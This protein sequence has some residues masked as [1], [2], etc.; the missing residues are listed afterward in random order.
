M[1]GV[2][3]GTGW[4]VGGLVGHN[5][6]EITASHATVVESG[7]TDNTGSLVGVNYEGEIVCQLRH[8]RGQRETGYDV[9]G[10]VGIESGSTITA[11]YATGAVSRTVWY[12][13]AGG[14]VGYNNWEGEIVASY[15]TGAVGGEN[16][17][18]VV[19]WGSTW[20]GRYELS[21]PVIGT[22]LTSGPRVERR[23]HG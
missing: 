15:A 19:S 18:Q 21:V 23:R 6:G 22:R 1:T 3:R 4:G 17:E 7:G 12:G 5:D 16:I 20:R 11:S 14:L 2:V 9:G 8:G 13:Y 10:L